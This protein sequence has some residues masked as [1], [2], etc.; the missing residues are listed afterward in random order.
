MDQKFTAEIIK[1]GINYCV[2]VPDKVVV[3]LLK[4]SNKR[5]GPVLIKGHVNQIALGTNL[6][7]YSGMWRIYLNEIV[8]KAAA[9]TVGDSV[10]LWLQFDPIARMPPMPNFFRLALAK[11]QEAKTA[12]QLLPSEKRKLIVEEIISKSGTTAQNN[13]VI[14]TVK[15]LLQR[16]MRSK[17]RM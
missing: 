4:Q 11:S 6:V 10:D 17:A 15:M 12:W 9:V 3:E 5:A 13:A 14:E 2:I 16:N 8:R 7:K 1:I